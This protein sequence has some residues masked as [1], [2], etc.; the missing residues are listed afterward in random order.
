M[1][2]ISKYPYFSHDELLEK[3]MSQISCQ[4]EV[5]F[6]SFR[7]NFL[8][9]EQYLIV[10]SRNREIAHSFY[11][12][13]FYKNNFFGYNPATMPSGYF[14]TDYVASSGSQKL[15]RYLLDEHGCDHGLLVLE[16]HEDF[17]DMFAF[18]SR[19]QNSNI[20][21]FYLNQKG[22]FTQFI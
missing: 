4:A 5:Q 12:K 6:I 3:L 19:P 13:E 7:R 1:V 21:N 8:N 20:N 17:C 10:H 2:D 14:M 16:K 22:L 18:G 15:Y 11:A 9:F